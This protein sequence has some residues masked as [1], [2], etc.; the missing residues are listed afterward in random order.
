MPHWPLRRA[1]VARK[2]GPFPQRG[3]LWA[4]HIILIPYLNKNKFNFLLFVQT[5]FRLKQSLRKYLGV[6]VYLEQAQPCNIDIVIRTG[7]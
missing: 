6:L 4:P 5:V 1:G 3:V 2:P 7:Q